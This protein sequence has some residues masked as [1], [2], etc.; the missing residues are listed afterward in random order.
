MD[1]K[2]SA[3]IEVDCHD[4]GLIMMGEGRSVLKGGVY[5]HCQ[6]AEWKPVP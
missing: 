4:Q 3:G 1:C 2:G 5:K 6:I